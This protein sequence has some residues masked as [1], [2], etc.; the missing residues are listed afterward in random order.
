MRVTR[1]GEK[2]RSAAV[3]FEM[4]PTVLYRLATLPD[5]IAAT[6]TPDALPTDPRTGRI[7]GRPGLP[8]PPKASRSQEP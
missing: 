8:P 4:D 3:F 2:N 7:M 6:L 5:E 1:F